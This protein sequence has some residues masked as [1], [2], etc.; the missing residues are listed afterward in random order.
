MQ[1]PSGSLEWLCTNRHGSFALGCGDR[2]LRRKYHGLLNVRDPGHGGPW[3][4]LAEVHETLWFDDHTSELLCDALYGVLQPAELREFRGASE[5][6]AGLADRSRG[7]ATHSYRTRGIDIERSVRLSPAHDQAELSY[8]VRGVQAPV[9]LSLSP[10]L[11]C[12]PLHDLTHENPFLDGA[13]S[14]EAG[15]VRMHPYAGM[16]GLAFA[17]RGA[18]A[19]LEERGTWYPNV[20]YPWE[21]ER[22][23]EA[24]EDLFSPGSFTVELA[25][26]GEFT[27]VVALDHCV[28]PE[29]APKRTS[30]RPAKP[31]DVLRSKLER[32]AG[33]FLVHGRDGSTAITAGF[34]W[35][36]PWSR[37]TL[38]ALPG[39]HLVWNDFERSAAV[40]DSLLKARVQGLIPNIPA[41]AGETANTSSVDATLLFV[42]AVQWL[43]QQ[44][45]ED[46]VARFMPAVCELLEALAE[47]RDPRMRLDEGIGVWTVRGPWALTWM[48]AMLDGQPVTPRAG[49]AVE[50]DALAYNAAM[51]ALGW[52]EANR[53]TFARAFKP[54]LRDAEGRFMRRY[55][56]ETRGTLADTHDGHRADPALRPNQL[57]ALA[58]PHRLVPPAQARSALDA[59]TTHLLTPAGLRTVAPHDPAY[60]G[61]Y[62]GSQRER[63]RAY[64]QG[65]VWPWLL[66]LYADAVLATRGA[67]P[68]PALLAPCFDFFARH[69]DGEGCVGQVGEVFSGDAPHAPG[70][71]PA[72]AWS[73][74]ELL[75]AHQ[76][77]HARAKAST[78]PSTR[79][80]ATVQKDTA[81]KR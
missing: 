16:P 52:A 3:S 30:E 26:D 81:E 42:R 18:E 74:S 69:I 21:A 38:I 61:H 63:D 70:G 40:L 47:A 11:R 23:Y 1:A 19:R 76:L 15:E 50:I 17:V 33:Q 27:F 35:F 64:H 67:D 60:R 48:D 77:V 75:R 25:G 2:R 22:G 41:L 36:G 53:A 39:F 56:D 49:Y 51:F 68:L 79:K 73:V 4:V 14:S 37:D 28:A 80:S 62:G 71:A 9:R 13:L 12:R 32:A 72:Q 31:A 10:I 55:W 20:H 57:W 29:P 5:V 54:R 34:P 66:G 58:L 43:G 65:T 46:R 78:R 8:R 59:I 7:Q 44:E 24:S 6:Q 45:G